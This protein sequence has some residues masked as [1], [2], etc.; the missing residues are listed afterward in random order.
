MQSSQSF[1][2][3]RDI[4][5]GEVDRRSYALD[6][7][8][9][10]YRSHGFIEIETPVVESLDVLMG[11]GGG[12]NEKLTFKLLRRGDKLDLATANSEDDLVDGGLRFDLTVP[13][14]RYY[15]ANASRL[16]RPFRSIQIGS[17]FRAERP[18]KGRFR[19]FTQ[20]DID[21]IGDPSPLA[22]VELL[23]GSGH[24]LHALGVE[25]MEI[26]LNDRRAL[27]QVLVR[28]GISQELHGPAMISLDKLDKIAP[29]LVVE[30]MSSRGIDHH[31]GEAVI[32]RLG[33]VSGS[34]ALDELGNAGVEF[35]VLESLRT[36]VEHVHGAIK[37]M[38]VR[39]DPLCVR[40]LGYYT[41]TVYEFSHPLWSTSL[42]GGGRYDR[43]LERFGLEL[44]ACGVSLGF[45]RISGLLAEEGLGM[46]RGGRRL[47][48]IFDQSTE[49]T[50][51]LS[52]ARELRRSGFQVV[53]VAHR[54]G[55]RSPMKRLASEAEELKAQGSGD[56]FWFQQL[57]LDDEPRLLMH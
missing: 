7:I 47:Y 37:G 11:S 20:A 18:Q 53:L 3:M 9:A 35:E 4:L 41:S 40:G 31:V 28:A 30:E 10:T 1:R 55:A 8:R 34:K 23:I 56:E 52:H 25:G 57:H 45:E 22:E 33:S 17:V 5:P 36:I 6:L 50:A 27:E 2:G 21:I 15:A 13:L 32:E 54:N 26:R 43:M 46:P 12:E 39:I 49:M 29:E 44:P 24:A 38:E 42:A 48:L 16:P 14:C 19:Q 51:A